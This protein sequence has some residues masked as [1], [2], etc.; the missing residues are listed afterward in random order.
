MTQYSDLHVVP[1][2][3]PRPFASGFSKIINKV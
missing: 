2:Y 1:W 3:K